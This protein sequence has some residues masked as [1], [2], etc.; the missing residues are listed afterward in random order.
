MLSHLLLNITKN[1]LSTS[2]G[3]GF[4][5]RRGSRW[6]YIP[7]DMFWRLL[8]FSPACSG[9][10]WSCCRFLQRVHQLT[11]EF[12]TLEFTLLALSKLWLMV[13]K[14]DAHTHTHTQAWVQA[15]RQNI[16]ANLLIQ[17]CSIQSLILNFR[18]PWPITEQDKME[19]DSFPLKMNHPFAF[20]GP[21]SCWK[22]PAW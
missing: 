1:S 20:C 16:S 6:R 15:P 21:W 12:K 8:R 10:L 2:I 9:Q 4:S 11:L 14:W 3:T 19:Q 17:I 18:N 7:S 13:L 22:P 5:P